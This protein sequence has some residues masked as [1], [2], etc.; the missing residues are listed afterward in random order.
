MRIIT[1][2]DLR[3][4]FPKE[5]SIIKFDDC[6]FYR[7]R[8]VRCQ[9]TKAVDI[10]AW[11]GEIL[12]M[13]EAKDFRRE[14]IK[15]QPRLTGGELAIEVAQKVRDTISG[16]FGAYRWKNEEFHDF[17]KA[18]FPKAKTKIQIIL[19]LEEYRPQEKA[20]YFKLRRSN[21]LKIMK[22][23]MKFLNVRSFIYSKNDLPDYLG[24]NVI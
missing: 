20:Q 4:S 6:N 5:W 22:H 21:L 18:L 7:H 11:S 19:L 9:E 24:W 3:F 15:N 10:L 1:E 2:G 17:Y 8:I 16:I 14:R 12:Y 23:H 13:I